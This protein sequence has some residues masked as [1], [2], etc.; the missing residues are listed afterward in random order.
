[1]NGSVFAYKD[2]V[3]RVVQVDQF[4]PTRIGERFYWRD[5]ASAVGLMITLVLP[6]GQTLAEWFPQLTEAKPFADRVAVFWLLYPQN[7]HDS[8]VQISWSLSESQ[9]AL[10]D[11][12]ERLNRAIFL[13]QKREEKSDYDIALSF[14]GEERAYVEEVANGLH[15]AGVRVFYDRL[16][17]AN[18]WGKNLYEYLNEIYM[19]RAR[20][21]ALFISKSYAA[22]R[23]TNHERQSAQAR[24]LAENRDYILP[25][26]FDDTEIPGLLPTI[27]YVSGQNRSPQEIVKLILEKLET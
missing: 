4:L 23:W 1:M 18:L 24:A 25:I 13:S 10:G 12:V 8:T 14:A 19:K 16:E 11:D 2:S 27:S 22:K 7:D 3:E 17:E 9:Y 15:T 20:Y 5:H 6:P 21:T 26:R